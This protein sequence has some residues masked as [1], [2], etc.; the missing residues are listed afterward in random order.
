MD[1]HYSSLNQRQ[2]GQLIEQDCESVR[3]DQSS[4][5]AVYDKDSDQEIVE[6][7][8]MGKTQLLLN[9]LLATT[10]KLEASE[11]LRSATSSCADSNRLMAPKTTSYHHLKCIPIIKDGFKKAEEFFTDGTTQGKKLKKQ[12]D[13]LLTPSRG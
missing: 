5:E 1:T 6:E 11:D 10:N 12:I 13:G 4:V 2:S 7:A 3:L 9:H 8:A